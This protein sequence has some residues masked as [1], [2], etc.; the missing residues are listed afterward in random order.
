MRLDRLFDAL[1]FFH[2]LLVDMQA[3]GGVDYHNIKVF[4]LS[5]FY[6]LFSDISRTHTRF[7]GK[8]FHAEL[9]TKNL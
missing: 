6:R 8:Y 3:T 5:V 7:A 2:H 9:I 4:D 1:Y